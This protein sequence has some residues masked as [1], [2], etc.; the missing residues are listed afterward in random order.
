MYLDKSDTW[1]KRVIVDFRD[2]MDHRDQK[3]IKAEMDHQGH[4]DRKALEDFRLV[5]AIKF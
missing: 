2:Q 1:V 3:V 4:K 5:I